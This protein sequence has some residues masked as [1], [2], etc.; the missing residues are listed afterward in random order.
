VG[1]FENSSRKRTICV[2]IPNKL[3]IHERMKLT[4]TGIVKE[5]RGRYAVDKRRKVN[6]V[7][8]SYRGTDGL[9]YRKQFSSYGTPSVPPVGTHDELNALREQ[10]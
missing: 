3:G 1:Y 8:A 4:L 10:F 7:V 5:N 6:S 9:E 2:D